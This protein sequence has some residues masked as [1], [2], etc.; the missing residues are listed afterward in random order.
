MID[1]VVVGAGPAGLAASAALTARQIEHVV[2]ERGRAGETWR[3]QRWDSFQLNTAGWMNLLL[4]DQPP[5]AYATGAEVVR[6]LER[7]AAACP[8]HEGVEVTRLDPA[9][10]GYVLRTGAGDVLARCL[11]VTTGDQNQP[12]VP[13]LARRFPATVAQFHTASY[14][15]PGQ[16]PDGAV[17]VVGSAQSGCQ[18]A[19]DLLA[20][21]HRVILATSRVGRVP[22]RHR[23]RETIE[24]L[25]E[26][27]FMEQ[28]PHDLPDPSVMRAAM[29]IIAP[30][31]GLS[32][33]ALAR[34]GV[35]L[36]GRLAAVD[37]E[38]VAFDDCVAAN[39]AAGDAFA[40]RAR[41]MA[42]EAIRRRGPDAPPAEPDEHDAPIDLDPPSS[43]DLRAERV[44]SVVWR[45]GFGGEFGWLGPGLVGAEGQPV[46]EGAAGPV[47]GL[48]YLGLRWLT[49]RCSG[50]LLGFPGD[51]AAVADAARAYLAA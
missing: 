27:G 31:R 10:E 45:T 49:R 35:T 21:G 34:A 7:L 42:D 26:A 20:G 36:A 9:G 13:A 19:E 5:D 28:R 38:R 37:G 4:G 3:A 50:L 44:G 46:R 2:L 32:L 18:I 39:I 24:W 17:L 12:R 30:G 23:G 47:P 11:V 14:R 6:R 1:C 51:A 15:H 41:A 22:F 48:W 29:P 33:P 40:A 25:A 8:V 16:L 43:L